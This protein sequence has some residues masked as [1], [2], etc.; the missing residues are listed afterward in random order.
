MLIL[1]FISSLPFDVHYWTFSIVP[2]FIDD[3]VLIY[4][5]KNTYK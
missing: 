2:F 5:F 3:L 1:K 4:D